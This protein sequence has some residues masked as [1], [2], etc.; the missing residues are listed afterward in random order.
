MK[1]WIAIPIVILFAQYSFAGM[2]FPYICSDHHWVT[3][4]ASGGNHPIS[5]YCVLPNGQYYETSYLEQTLCQDKE[6]TK[7]RQYAGKQPSIH[8]I[9]QSIEN[10][11]KDQYTDV[12]V[13]RPSRPWDKEAYTRLQSK[14]YCFKMNDR[15]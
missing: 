5:F 15:L 12:R 6:S 9:V 1:K 11:L 3:L 8:Q 7:F 10:L 14:E 4:I 2:R 13:E